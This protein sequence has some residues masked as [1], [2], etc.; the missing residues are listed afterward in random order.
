MY[1][2]PGSALWATWLFLIVCCASIRPAHANIVTSALCPGQPGNSTYCVYTDENS[3]VTAVQTTLGDPLGQENFGGY[4]PGN[5]NPNVGPVTAN[6]SGL[7]VCGPPNNCGSGGNPV[8]N[9]YGN[10]AGTTN[11]GQISSAAGLAYVGFDYK[12][13]AASSVT[14]GFTGGS[15]TESPSGF[16]GV[17]GSGASMGINTD[18]V[19]GLYYLD[20]VL[21][22]D[23]PGI[24]ATNP[25]Y[26]DSSTSGGGCG[27]GKVCWFWPAVLGFDLFFDPAGANAYTY[28]TL[29]GSLFTSV[30][31]F[32]SGFAS[33]FDISSGGTNYGLFGPGQKLIFPGGGVSQFTISGITPAVNGSSPTA[34]PI[35]IGLNRIGASVEATAFEQSGSSVP[36]PSFLGILPLLITVTWFLQRATN[37]TGSLK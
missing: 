20:N 11:V 29:D 18:T 13:P 32:P 19:N 9:G 31:G 36:E 4:S 6:G 17:I 1:R 14:F 23:G 10:F 22:A 33:A 26:P 7:V 27:S 8:P 2:V 30:S 3:F 5:Y 25:L 37:K 12:V 24:S 15:K 16:F 21:W 35:Q 34:F 28:Q